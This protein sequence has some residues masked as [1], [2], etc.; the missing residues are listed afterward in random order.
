MQVQY[1]EGFADVELGD[2]ISVAGVIGP[3]YDLRFIQELRSNES[4]FE[5]RLE[6]EKWV[7]LSDVTVIKR[8]PK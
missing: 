5:C 6:G 4:Y 1:A 2:I 3:I 7:P 8:I